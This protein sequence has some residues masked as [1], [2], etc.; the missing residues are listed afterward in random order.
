MH[1]GIKLPSLGPLASADALGATAVLAEEVGF[2]SGWVSDHVVMP[3][4]PRSAYPMSDDG[5]WPFPADQAFQDPMVALT[6]VAARTTTLQVGTSVLVLPLRDPLLLAKQVASLDALS[7]GRVVL[8]IGSGWMAEEFE[9]VGRSFA[10]RG[11]RTDAAVAD[12]RA[13]WGPDPFLLDGDRARHGPVA[14][15]P[16]PRRGAAVPIVVGGHSP[17]ARR[18]AVRLGDGWYAAGLSPDAFAEQRD[19]LVA[20]AE[21]TGRATPPLTGIRMP[22]VP[23]EACTDLIDRYEAA[24]A[25]FAVVDLDYPHLSLTDAQRQVEALGRAVTPADRPGGPLAAT[26]RTPD[27][28]TFGHHQDR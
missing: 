2:R 18:R 8:G 12:L 22:A 5:R 17:A 7:G 15:A 16:K 1:I 26:S 23:P 13:C 4:E 11:A 3:T 21:R 24:G 20:E 25:D 19:A 14:M 27:R 28:R 10:D 9:L 6:W